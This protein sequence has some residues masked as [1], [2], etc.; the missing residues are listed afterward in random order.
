MGRTLIYKRTHQGDPDPV[1]GVFGCNGCMG[2]VREWN[3]D[4]VI[5]IGGIGPEPEEWGIDGKLNW[6]GLG[7]RKGDMDQKGRGRMVSFEHFKF[8]DP[9]NA[10]ILAT[11]APQ[12]AE[13]MYDHNVRTL[14][15]LTEGEAAEVEA[16]LA[17][18]RTA[19]PSRE[20]PPSTER[21]ASGEC[22]TSRKC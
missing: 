17:R 3:F 11:I 9:A 2:R 14:M 12:L 4:S 6:I 22:R 7:A 19:P 20:V 1:Q 8:F 13:H 18:A 15:T 16:I 10:P 5:G 21:E